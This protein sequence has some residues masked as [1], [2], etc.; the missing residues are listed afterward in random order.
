MILIIN[1]MILSGKVLVLFTKN[2]L[3]TQTKYRRIDFLVI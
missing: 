1:L 3:L 2:L